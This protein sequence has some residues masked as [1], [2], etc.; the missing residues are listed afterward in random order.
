VIQAVILIGG[1]GERM[2]PL[3]RNIR[4]A[5]LP[6]G[7]KRVIDHI[8]DRLPKGMPLAISVNDGGSVAAISEALK[9]DEP[10]M[11]I[12]GDNY[13]SENLDGFV[14]AFT[15]ETLI[16][17]YDVKEKEKAKKYGVVET[18]P[19]G[20]VRGFYEKPEEPK[21]TLVST[22]L[23]IIPPKLYQVIRQSPRLPDMNLGDLIAQL[24][25]Y[26]PVHSY[27]IKGIWF[28]I[29]SP[30]S[31]HEALRLVWGDIL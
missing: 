16:G 23:Y 12:C 7:K 6:L 28:D 25:E 11:V 4:K 19:S 20:R 2:L 3:T 15:G 24:I 9:G 8:I 31:Y 21:T 13:F 14:Q 1:K 27:L 29:G 5:Y 17:I 30:E 10:T 26:H 18:Y 22:G